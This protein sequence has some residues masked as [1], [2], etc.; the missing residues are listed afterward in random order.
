MSGLRPRTAAGF[1]P[2]VRV[3]RRR[4]GADRQPDGRAGGAKHCVSDRDG[5]DRFSLRR[6]GR[7]GGPGRVGGPDGKRAG[8]WHDAPVQPRTRQGSSKTS[9]PASEVAAGWGTRRRPPCPAW[10]GRLDNALPLLA[11]MVRRPAFRVPDFET[12]Q[13]AT[14]RGRGTPAHGPGFPR[15]RFVRPLRVR[16]PGQLPQAAGRNRR[17]AGRPRVPDDAHRFA[18][19]R[20][21]PEAAVLIVAGDVE[22]V[23]VL[24]LAEREFG[25]VGPRDRFR[26]RTP[27]VAAAP[28]A[29]R[30][31]R[32]PPWIGP[33]GDPRR[34]C[35]GCQKRGGL[36]SADGAQPR[37]G[38]FVFPRG[39]T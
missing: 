16:R 27:G 24:S 39:S 22:P 38:G 17:H 11:E 29:G 33:V 4:N 20:Y 6:D 2:P 8:R 21:G 23:E 12:L 3:S 31:T 1:D 9:G 18:L 25:G 5:D 10:P 15:E 32:A 37:A 34:P 14:P 36:P 13:G 30:A 26:P 28:R 7:A 19:A 35:R